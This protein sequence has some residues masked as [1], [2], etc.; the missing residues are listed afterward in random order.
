MNRHLFL[1]LIPSAVFLGGCT[2]AP[3]HK[4]PAA[5][6]PA[7]WPTGD[8]YKGAAA[9]PGAP[10]ATEIKWRDFF[11][12]EKLRKVIDA[13]LKGNRDLRVAALNV[14]RARAYYGIQRAELLPT[15]EATGSWNKQR[16]PPGSM[17]FGE[18]L[19]IE[20]YE[21][22]LG[23]TA[24]EIDFFG[25]IRSLKD[26]AL[27]EYLATAEVR[28]EAQ[29]LLV[30]GVA[31]AYLT[32]AADRENLKLARSTI[33]TQQAVYDLIRR[34]FDTGVS[35]E[36]DLRQAQTRVEA[37]RVD[38]A[39]YTRA[40][41]QDQNALDLLVGSKVPE[42][43]LPGD[44]SLVSPPREFS[45]GMSSEVLLKRP[46]ILQAE[47]QLKAAEA[48]IGAARAAFF[49]RISLT[50]AIGTASKYLSGLFD[51]GSEAWSFA[52]QIVMPIFDARIYSGLRVTK[53]E[54]EIAVAQYE[55]AIQTA[56]REVA[57]TLAFQ[58]TVEGQMAAQQALVD[59]VSEA[60][61]L[62]NLRYTRGVDSFLAV[63][64]AQRSLYAAQHGL[65]AIRL[66]RLAN[67]V[68]LYAVL[69]GGGDA[70]PEAAATAAGADKTA[71]GTA[72]GAKA[73]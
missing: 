41:A 47:H 29:I 10:A 64:D 35:T 8:A 22:G 39:L 71:T 58:G 5:P 72:E 20:R 40:V 3:E 23:I 15:V 11:T 49:P 43:L 27:E 16:I 73:G 34:R 36:L 65:I 56:F 51:A 17:G 38:E 42:D 6:V 66:A 25:R 9:E 7:A 70:P 53:V 67:G 55:R 26:R 28:R 12:D 45:P 32:L 61:R 52:P 19:K 31:G 62:S 37:A 18:P 63:L 1:L 33:E 57:D 44:L 30:S 68:R 50:T 13:A 24:W 46:D 2:M 21:V 14:D 59:A 60:Y 48:N 54:R 4:R 69:G